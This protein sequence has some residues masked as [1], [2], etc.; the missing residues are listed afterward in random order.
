MAATAKILG[1]AKPNIATS[2]G[3][4]TVPTGY[5]AQV[6]IFI[7]NQTSTGSQRFRI[8]IIPNGESTGSKHWIVYDFPIQSNSTIKLDGIAL[9]SGDKIICYSTTSSD[10]SYSV[11]GLEIN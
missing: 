2:T 5:Q 1:Q 7:S 10:L 4:Y 6:N 11:T 8:A 9:N 3:L